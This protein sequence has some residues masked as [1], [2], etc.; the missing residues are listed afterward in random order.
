LGWSTN[1]GKAVGLPQVS[2]GIRKIYQELQSQYETAV[3]VF[4]NMAAL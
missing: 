1:G 3:F 4:I 2:R